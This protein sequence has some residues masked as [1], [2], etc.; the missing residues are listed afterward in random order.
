MSGTDLSWKM[1]E[2][3]VF[4][5]NHS[6]GWISARYAVRGLPPST[7]TRPACRKR[8]TTPWMARAPPLERRMIA[9][10]PWPTMDEKS[11]ARSSDRRSSSNRNSPE[12][13][14]SP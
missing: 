5:R 9:V 11:M 14:S 10:T 13:R 3:V 6:Q 7:W 1:R 4:V 2:S 8:V 12:I